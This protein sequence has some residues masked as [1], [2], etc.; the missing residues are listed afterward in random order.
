M[1]GCVPA[2]LVA[3][4]AC[5]GRA[6]PV[7]SATITGWLVVPG[8]TGRRQ[9]LAAFIDGEPTG[10]A[11]VTRTETLSPGV[12]KHALG[13]SYPIPWNYQD[14]RSHV[15]SLV[16]PDGT[17]IEFPTRGGVTRANLRFRFEEREHAGWAPPIPAP[18]LEAGS[19]GSEFLGLTDP[20]TGTMITGW[21]AHRQSPEMAVRLR[22][23][24]DGQAAG[25]VL[26]DQ[27]RDAC[28]PAEAISAARG[29]SFDI[30]GRF[31][32]GMT[33]T[34]AILFEDGTALPLRQADGRT[35]SRLT[36]T[37]EPASSI[38]GVV[39]GLV[40]DA[41]RGWVLR[42]HHNI[43]EA[44]VG[45]R[46]QV[47]CNGIVVDEII[48]D[49]PRI[50]VAREHGCDPGVGFEFKLPRQCRTGME[51]EFVLKALP[52]GEVLAGCPLP[53]RHRAPDSADELRAL[54]ETIKDLCATAFKLQRQMREVVPV[55]EATVFNYDGWA[56]R[57]L[58]RLRARM[59]ASAPLPDD[60]PLI[61]VVMPVFRTNLAHL[62][63]A[64]E[65]VRTQTYRN[66]ELIVVDDGSRQEALSACLREYASR[67]PRIACLA[68]ARNHG[69]SAATNAAL[70]KAKGAYVMLFDHDDLL[71]EVALE[72]M[73]RHALA[74]AAKLVYSDEDKIDEFGVLS[75]P[76]LKP[77]W[78]Y[79]LLLGVN[80]VCHLVMIERGLL[81]KVGLLRPDCDGAQDHDL[82]LR[83]SERC[84]P[85][86]I[87]HLPEILYHW[88][89]SSAS[90]ADSGAAKP[91]AVAA[92][93]RAVADHLARRGIKG[94][95]V[96][97]VGSSTTY[98]V[99]WPLP[100]EP[101]VTVIVPFKD[102]IPTTRRC[103]EALLAS[104]HWSGWRVVLVDNESATPEAVEFCREAAL[105][106]RVVVMRIDEPFNYSRL[107][108][109]AA[110]EHPA[111]YYVFLNNDVFLDQKDWLRVLMGEALADPK[112]G[113]VGPK[114]I[115]PDGTVQHAGVVLGVG[116]IADHAFRGIPGDH[117][118]YLYRARC[119]QQYSAVTAACMLCRADAFMD[120]GG[121]DEHDLKVAFNDVDLCLKIGN[122][123]WR[124][125]WTPDLVAEHHES[126]SRGDDMSPAKAERFFYEN[127]VM[128]E[129]WHGI[130]A[131]DPYYNPN[132]SREGG[133]YTDLA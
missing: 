76:N 40:A 130:L 129:R 17:A 89:K 74:T 87:A 15:L 72:A 81:R 32:D 126:L 12:P 24:V 107:N 67:D 119:A 36:F 97:T 93:L 26:C 43:G 110:R 96:E 125:I 60:A 14:G 8:R 46:V 84:K 61:S 83:L 5:F 55:T 4:T 128:L 49:K 94:F 106:P 88:R 133:L 7:Q 111:D 131:A 121:F 80:Y 104:T 50:D 10:A 132:F 20:F 19:A 65:S 28:A 16:L 92:G 62:T 75:E 27:A 120:V 63:A 35:E 48:A 105:N 54:N 101:S 37:A 34:L 70:R 124:V 98:R 39:D 95:E 78:N 123:G 22:V 53:V 100:S 52:E 71:V 99:A 69:I 31:L 21:V 114:L 122:R 82:L 109:L 51:F 56:R 29:F 103:L 57:Y 41:I 3:A 115:Y 64:I 42:R 38:E 73:L 2:G 25:T 23:F 117:P 90:T 86:Q 13:F 118:G 68:L 47:L 1:D 18:P 45:L 102:Q 33:H 58:A 30:P 108:N 127:H 44:E 79:R 113:I 85:E 112:V 77:D 9:R 59:A 91:Y 11:V 66:W 116:G 6:D